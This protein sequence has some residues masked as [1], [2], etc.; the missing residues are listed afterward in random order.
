MVELNEHALVACCYS[1]NKHQDS[2]G[3]KTGQHRHVD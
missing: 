3:S 2:Q 1:F